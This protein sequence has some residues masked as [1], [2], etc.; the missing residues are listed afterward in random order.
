VP[1]AFEKSGSFDNDDHYN[2]LSE[3]DS[4]DF[5]IWQAK[6]YKNLTKY[7]NDVKIL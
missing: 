5:A 4:A 1:I 7:T 6:I 3:Y 2:R